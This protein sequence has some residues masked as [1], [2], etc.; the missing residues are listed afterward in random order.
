[1]V[2]SNTQIDTLEVRFAHILQPIRDLAKNWDIDIARNLEDYLDELEHITIS[3]DGGMTT[4]NFAQ[5]ALLVQGSAC[6]YSRKV[7]YLYSL[8]FQVLDLLANKKKQTQPSS[9]DE[10]NDADAHCNKT[11]DEEFLTLDDLPE[12]KNITKK[13][14]LEDSDQNV[15]LVPQLPLSLIPLEEGEKGD[16][17]LISKKGEVLASRNDFKINT[18]CLHISG[19][20]LLDMSHLSLLEKSLQALATSTPFPTKRVESHIS[21]LPECNEKG[22]MPPADLLSVHDSAIN[23]DGDQDNGEDPLCP[24]VEEDMEQQDAAVEIGWDGLHKPARKAKIVELKPQKP[25]PDPWNLLDPHIAGG[26]TDMPFKK[27]CKCKLPPGLNESEPKKRKKKPVTDTKKL[28][29]V[30]EYLISCYSH[31]AKFSKNSLKVTTFPELEHPY[32]EEFKRRQ[33]ILKEQMSRARFTAATR[34]EEDKEEGTEEEVEGGEDLD[35]DFDEAQP[36]AGIEEEDNGDELVGSLFNAIN[37]GIQSKELFSLTIQRMAPVNYDEGVVL[38]SYE[39]LVQKHVE[40]YLASA[41]EYAQITEL[42]KRVSEWEEKILPKLQEEENHEPFDI[43]K[44]GSKVIGNLA[45]GKTLPFQKLV[46][47]NPPF[48]ICR[49][50]LAT[51]MLANTSNVHLEEKGILFEGM[52]KF[53]VEL[54]STRR[55]FEDLAD[56]QAPSLTGH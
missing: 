43:N 17:P 46:A 51:L 49:V 35:G 11:T 13:E 48:E 47:N 30:T 45:K 21:S 22:D 42:S 12:G 54:L 36:L 53:E 4:M 31:K 52:D 14:N 26:A 10:G 19:T 2:T 32:W 25:K 16:N 33:E 55:H 18:S 15:T 7:E 5:A 29:P 39:Q 8:V 40:Q 1:M 37:E 23:D 41:Q 3:F 6:V 34:G 27:G 9:T 38:T 56:Y 44:Y 28:P 20:L 24:P 50:F